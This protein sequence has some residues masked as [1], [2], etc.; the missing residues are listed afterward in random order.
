[1]RVLIF[2]E[3]QTRPK[4]QFN[5]LDE[6]AGYRFKAWSRYLLLVACYIASI[7]TLSRCI[8]LA[9][10]PYSSSRNIS[11]DPH[12]EPLHTGVS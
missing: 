11:R 5:E 10:V 7:D 3:N 12:Y 9:S 6:T 8:S 2:K 1:M 4:E